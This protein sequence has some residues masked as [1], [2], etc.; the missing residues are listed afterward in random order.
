M[1]IGWL[2]LLRTVPWADVIRSAPTVADGAKKLWGAVSKQP[3]SPQAPAAT[4]QAQV[5]ALESTVAE[6]HS[7]MLA[8]TELIKALAEQN[9]QLIRR[10][11]T[12][13]VRVLWLLGAT[14]VAG[15]IAVSSLLLT[16]AR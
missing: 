9:T 11:E 6:L 7:Q 4:L 13:R 12:N 1:A 15:V 8:S 2:S 10:I 16:L 3:P 14:A 5:A